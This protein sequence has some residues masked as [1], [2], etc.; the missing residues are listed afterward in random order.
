MKFYSTADNNLK[1]SFERAVIEGL[2]PSRGLYFP[3]SIHQHSKS[4]LNDLSK[5]TLPEIGYEVMKPY[6]EGDIDNSSLASIVEE[7]LNFPI[8]LK[9]ID[10]HL[11]T[12]ELFHGPTMAFKDVGARF[13]SRCLS[14]FNKEK[15]KILVATSGDTGGAVANGFYK[16]EGVEVIILY[17]GNKIS[18]IQEQQ[19]TTLGENITALEVNGTFD[20]CQN[21]VKEAF[22]DN[23]LK[24]K[25]NLSSANS[26]NIARWMPQSIYYYWIK[27]QLGTTNRPLS[28]SVPSGNFG[29]ISAGVLAQKSGLEIDQFI[30]ATNA[31][32]IVPQYIKTGIYDPKP[33]VSTIANA[34]DVGDPSNHLRMLELF[35]HDHEKFINNINGYSLC[36]SEIKEV[37]KDV[38]HTFD[39]ILDPHG[40]IAYNAS[41]EL[42][43]QE[44]DRVFLETAHPVKFRDVVEPIIGKKLNVPARL[45]TCLNK[46]KVAINMSTNYDD[47]KSFL[48]KH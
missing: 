10:D 37:I 13:M 25:M 12:L 34:M 4:F 5:M 14:H 29:N 18:D 35:D 36:D 24:S 26:I 28:I 42:G 23:E 46:E 43:N 9:E 44:Q 2:A 16:V 30:A 7:T 27:A 3:E 39:Y 47:F 21:L 17:P 48:L 6:T 8:P 33:S 15:V 31:N 19:L 20:D 38:H 1:V 41:K 22:L 45:E 40:A 32:D 11:F